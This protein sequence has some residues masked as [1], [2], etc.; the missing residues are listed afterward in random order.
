MTQKNAIVLSLISHT[1]IGKTTLTRTLLKSDVGEV[2]DAP[3]VTAESEEFVMIQTEDDALILWDTPGFGNVAQL[4]KRLRGE[5]GAVSWIMHEVVDRAFN[6]PLYSSLEAAR[7]VRREADVVLYLVNIQENPGDAGYVAQ[8]LELL[9]AL[10]KPVIMILNQV[11]R[12]QLRGNL[13]ISQLVEH[14]RRHYS[15]HVCLKQVILL[16]AF[17]RTWRQELA[18]ID[19]VASLL[20][21][22]KK[23]VLARLRARFVLVQKT[24]SEECIRH[25]ADTLW[26][27]VHQRIEP[28]EDPSR[29]QVFQAMLVELQSHLDEYLDLLVKRHGIEA[30]GQARLKADIRQITGLVGSKLSEKR[31]GLLAGALAS[32]GTGL[33]ADLVAGGLTFGGGALLGFLG[34]YLGGFSYARLLNFTGRQGPISWDA[35]ALAHLTQLLLTYY[36]LAAIHGRGRGKLVLEEA[37]PFLAETVEREWPSFIDEVNDF[38]EM[39]KAGEEREPENRFYQSFSSF[40]KRASDQILE[41]VFELPPGFSGPEIE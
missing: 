9:D 22:E 25:A 34:G 24:I 29:E 3:H 41:T 32:A 16:D 28:A 8:E 18:L 30:E 23:A 13:K 14:W 10:G 19:Q 5:G 31:S 40:F 17:T 36:L 39:A 6:R 26:F 7:N 38:I 11:R 2:R 37:A 21:Q 33:M 20:D 35:N 4:L 1:N 27:A 12:E 15:R